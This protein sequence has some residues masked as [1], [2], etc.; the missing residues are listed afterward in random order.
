MMEL[1]NHFFNAK[2]IT[3]GLDEISSKSKDKIVELFE[4]MKDIATRKEGGTG[5]YPS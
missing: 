5:I 2:V 1:S 3:D 4:E